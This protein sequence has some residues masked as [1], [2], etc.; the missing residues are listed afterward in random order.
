MNSPIIISSY[1]DDGPEEGE[2]LSDDF[3]EI[4]DDSISFPPNNYGKCFSHSENLPELSLSSVS[5][6]EDSIL[7]N[8]CSKR[9]KNFKERS[10]KKPK[11]LNSDSSDSESFMVSSQLKFQLKAA[12]HRNGEETQ[13]NPL[14]TRLLAM[15]KGSSGP[16]SDV[17]GNKTPIVLNLD[18]PIASLAKPES[19]SDNSELFGST[20]EDQDTELRQL[21][22]EALKTAVNNKFAKRK[23]KKIESNN[24][25]NEM[26]KEN[27]NNNLESENK[28][29][30]NQINSESNNHESDKNSLDED[31]D[32]LRAL[33][34]ASMSK[35][36]TNSQDDDPKLPVSSSKETKTLK[37]VKSSNKVLTIP[38]V[39]PLIICVNSDSDSDSECTGSPEKIPIK[40]NNI[41]IKTVINNNNNS[42]KGANIETS[43]DKFLKEQRAKVEKEV[44]TTNGTILKG[45]IK[46]PIVKTSVT[47]KS[48]I[49]KKQELEKS[50]LKFLPANKRE[51]YQKLQ[52]LLKL[53]KAQIKRNNAGEKKLSKITQ[54]VSVQSKNIKDVVTRSESVQTKSTQTTKSYMQ[55]SAKS[56]A[57]LKEFRHHEYVAAKREQEKRKE[58]IVLRNI[59]KKLQSNDSGRYLINFFFFFLI[60]LQKNRWRF[61]VNI[62]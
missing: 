2:I 44:E 35:K 1:T 30:N 32:V 20:Y 17:I 26:N 42:N 45:V 24:L 60:L 28:T 33:L 54:V 10:R 56:E 61:H 39:K 5:E 48:M 11:Q 8:K 43:I 14:M 57:R 7:R 58:T 41:D 53:R 13:K 21:R 16:E 49:L 52:N 46:K 36:I 27:T 6:Y 23:K 62:T 3:E 19:S 38:Q 34:L 25:I 55:L 47:N 18:D 15:E 29:D 51:E 22:I 9:R 4:S 31:E 40:E 37:T 59:L 50:A 12:V